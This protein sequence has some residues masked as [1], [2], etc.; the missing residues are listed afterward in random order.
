MRSI[1]THWCS[2]GTISTPRAITQEA[3]LRAVKGRFDGRSSLYTWLCAIA[4]NVWR[5]QCKKQGREIPTED[6]GQTDACAPSPEHQVVDRLD[7]QIVQDLLPLYHDEVVRP[8]TKAAVEAHLAECPDCAREYKEL[9]AQLPFEVPQEGI[10]S[11]Y[12]AMV[13]RRRRRRTVAAA[14]AVLIL[15]AVFILWPRPPLSIYDEASY[16]HVDAVDAS[17]MTN[18]EFGYYK[19]EDPAMLTVLSHILQDGKA[20]WRGF[21]GS[22]RMILGD[23][24]GVNLF[25]NGMQG[26]SAIFFTGEGKF[27]KG[28][29]QYQ[30]SAGTLQRLMHWMY[31]VQSTVEP[32][33]HHFSDF[34]A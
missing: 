4:K 14:V 18:E 11:K 21:A 3:F 30:L 33:E 31:Q 23:V 28:S 17:Y 8:K 32:T 29:S 10:G 5:N 1:A 34:T 12:T 6:S 13:R 19:I 7:C 26:K 27:Y 24:A 20:A 9:C 2:H 15:L 25:L 22:S 16:G